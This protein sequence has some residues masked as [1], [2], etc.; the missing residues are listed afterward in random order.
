LNS[1]C[2]SPGN[3]HANVFFCFKDIA[4]VY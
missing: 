3:Q 2:L 1:G 4:R